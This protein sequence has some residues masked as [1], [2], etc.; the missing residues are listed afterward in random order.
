[1]TTV[2]RP[3]VK[4]RFAPNLVGNTEVVMKV[5]VVIV[6]PDGNIAHAFTDKD[7]ADEYAWRMRREYRYDWAKVIP[8]PLD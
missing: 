8:V 7:K 5:Y 4:S 6:S 2:L 1:M 3:P